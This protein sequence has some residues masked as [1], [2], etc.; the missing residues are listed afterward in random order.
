MY[1]DFL[2]KLKS[3]LKKQVK[4]IHLLIYKIVL[5]NHFNFPRRKNLIEKIDFFIHFVLSAKLNF[6]N[7]V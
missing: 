1:I 2:K 7:D 4:V 5:K 3:N 6:L